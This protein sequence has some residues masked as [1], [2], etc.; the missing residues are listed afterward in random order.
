MVQGGYGGVLDTP[1]T[2]IGDATY[3]GRGPDFADIS[4][5]ASFH[6]PQ[7]EGGNILQQLR[8]G[9]SNGNGVNI[10]TPR[11]DPL[12]DRNNLPPSIGGAE[13]TPLLK[14]ATRNSIRQRSGKENGAV[15]LTPNLSRIDEND[16][17]PV[18]RMDASMYSTSRNQSYLDHT[19]PQI[20][21]SSVAST[22]LALATRR[23]GDK[24]P[25]Q[26]GNQLSLREQEN[27]IDKIEKENFGL[28]L[29]IHFLEE[30]LRKAGPGFHEAALKENTE[31]KVDKVTM[32]R[33]VH[34]FKKSLITAERELET[35]RQQILELQSRASQPGEDD[36]RRAEVERLQQ[37]LDEKE[38]DLRDLRQQ[39]AAGQGNEEEIE[40]LR[41]SIED[42][43]ADLRDRDRQLTEREDEAED[44]K[45][46]IEDAEA[47]AR[48]AEQKVREAEENGQN[49]DELDEAKETIQDL[50]LNIRRLEEQ[51]DELN[52]KLETAAT[53]KDRAERDLEELQEEM[54]NKSVVTKGLSRQIDERVTRLQEELDKAGEDYATLEKEY[55]E[56][57]GEIDELRAKVD[58][59]E[60]QQATT[61]QENPE[62]EARILELEA[63]LQSQIDEK[64]LIQ[65]RHDTLAAESNSL[66]RNVG[67]LQ[68][69]VEE[70]ESTVTRERDYA[71]E[72]EKDLRGQYQDELERLND[73]ISDL[74]AEIR[75]KDNIY[76]NDSEK[77]ETEKQTLEAER[78]R[79]EE[80]A[81]GLQR[82][83]DRLR[84]AEGSLSDRG[85]R[86]QD[87]LKLE[88][89]RHRSE[90]ALMTR[91]I[92]DLQDALETRQKMLTDLRSE[93]STV[94]DDLRQAQVEYQTQANKVISLEDQVEALRSRPTVITTPSRRE[95][96]ALKRECESLRE[97]LRT[98]RSSTEAPRS[99][100]EGTP[101][102]G[103]QTPTRLKW[104]LTDA[105]NKLDKVSSEK[106]SL[107]DTLASIRAEL[108][109]TQTSLAEIKAERDELDSQLRRTKHQDNDTLRVDQERLDLRTAKLKLDSEVRRLR[110]ENK[111]LSEQ[112]QSV[113]KSLESEIEKA[114]AEEDRLSQEIMQLQS[115]LRQASSV[116][117]ADNST[118]RRTIRDLE[119]RVEDYQTQLASA[120]ALLDG[121]GSSEVSIIRRDLTSA[122]QKEVE[123]L[124]REA[125]SKDIIKGLR[126][127]VADLESKL[128]DN[129]VSRIL[130]SPNGSQ[131][132]N[133]TYGGSQVMTEELQQQ[134]DDAEDQRVVLEEFLEEARQ[135]AE[136]TAAEHAQSLQRL[137]HQLD[138]AIRD[139][140]A[141]IV[142]AAVT[143]P[144]S[145]AKDGR[146]SKE[147]RHLRK[148]QAEIDNL[149]HDVRQQQALIEGL[150][151]SEVALR[152]KLERTRSERAAYRV[153][154]EKLQRNVAE[155]QRRTGL[156]E[157]ETALETVVRA[158]DA[159][160]DRH[161]KELRGL[162]MQ[163]DWMQARWEREAAM[164]TDAAY[165]KKF[166]Q[167]QLDI[168]TACNKAQLREL[169]HIRTKILHSRKPL[170]LPGS[171]GT[172]SSSFGDDARRKPTLQTFLVMARFVARM[173]LSA[174]RWAAQEVVRKR[175]VAATEERRKAKRTRGLRVVRVDEDADDSVVA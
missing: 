113:E 31:L 6:S 40:K 76:D 144:S 108:R 62:S 65:T 111:A 77:W 32:Q 123:F 135:Q 84:E 45:D 71:V 35:C 88:E 131:T 150:V 90:E 13:F 37:E 143:S 21:S 97:Q 126:R 64:D 3:L 50:E 159:A 139:R 128:H 30:A 81:A 157:A 39:I 28:K 8:N 60:H 145:K 46:K 149:E 138:K 174:R 78:N 36:G 110:D 162:V 11:R 124:Q 85:S 38:E 115:K 1:R 18:P 140:D 170:L 133:A 154:A 100:V 105:N 5:E 79:A 19:I 96:E 155:L 106:R 164:R 151:S 137:Q 134:L 91:Q 168:S 47:R 95:G 94:R 52:E 89:E 23:G 129:Q 118:T 107:E 14:S 153:S 68:M 122:R 146:S 156:V 112:R 121:D 48:E 27:V 87:G 20:D 15:S 26:D 167:L 55:T 56:A 132:A 136:E 169:E 109:T 119:R 114:A 175:L 59:L 58:Q 9:R 171:G 163:M 43:E 61:R 25:L 120:Q 165:A 34:R 42:L 102:R 2:N 53:E 152:R 117:T 63:E 54:A 86:L 74:Q 103:S 67:R 172:S 160:A 16:L 158:S 173:R 7:K 130:S 92:D 125:A 141:A 99:V 57:N 17:T 75:E 127:E 104:Q 148:T 73:D 101:N 98:L 4:Q 24:G 66:Q 82:T 166:I 80:K 49:S 72:I 161:R 93:L 83:I 22:P 70:L 142:A 33:E 12:T 147:A 10:R 116:E 29:K 44:L 69:E 41:D 51:V